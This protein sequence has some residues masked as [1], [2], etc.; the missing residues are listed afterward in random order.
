MIDGTTKILSSRGKSTDWYLEINLVDRYVLRHGP[1]ADPSEVTIGDKPKIWSP[2]SGMTLSDLSTIPAPDITAS[3]G[4]VFGN[5]SGPTNF[6]AS[7]IVGSSDFYLNASIGV[8]L[9]RWCSDK[10]GTWK[11]QLTLEISD[12]FTTDKQFLQL[13][14]NFFAGLG[15]QGGFIIDGKQGYWFGRAGYALI[16]QPVLVGGTSTVE[17]NGLGQPNFNQEWVPSTGATIV[18]PLTQSINVNAGINSYYSH[19]PANWNANLGFSFDLSKL[20]SAFK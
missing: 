16:D 11:Q 7:T 4:Y 17:F 1:Q 12:G 18:F 15:W 10:D 8:P 20:A 2:L 3:L 14:H 5:S 13:H 19:A 6:S 9:L